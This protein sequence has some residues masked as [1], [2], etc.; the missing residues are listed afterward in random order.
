M[1]FCFFDSFGMKLN[2]KSIHKYHVT[3]LGR[4]KIFRP[5]MQSVGIAHVTFRRCFFAKCW[6]EWWM[7]YAIFFWTVVK[8]KCTEQTGAF[9]LEICQGSFFTIYPFK[10]W[11]TLEKK[12]NETQLSFL[13][14]M[15]VRVPMYFSMEVL[16]VAF[17]VLCCVILCSGPC[18]HSRFWMAQWV[19]WLCWS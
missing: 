17:Q 2:K 5:S 15:P 14:E 12:K 3:V 7:C 18:N 8:G 6:S 11:G 9:L 1:F 10:S 19:Q 13:A 16:S 4:A